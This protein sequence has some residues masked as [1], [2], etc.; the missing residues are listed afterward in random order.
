MC[1]WCQ[2]ANGVNVPMVSTCQWCQRA[3]GVNVRILIDE[4]L[5]KHQFHLTRNFESYMVKFRG[6]MSR[7]FN[8]E[9]IPFDFFLVKCQFVNE[10]RL[11]YLK[12]S[13]NKA[14]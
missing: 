13:N 3:N 5:Q 2:C 1:Q 4:R 8:Q 12:T 7:I 6:I 10:I 11:E 14:S 9:L